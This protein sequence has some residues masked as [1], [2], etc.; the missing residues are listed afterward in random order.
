MSLSIRERIRAWFQPVRRLKAFR[1]SPSRLSIVGRATSHIIHL[2]SSA[3]ALLPLFIV[4]AALVVVVPIVT[5]PVMWLHGVGDAGATLGTLLTAQAAIAALTLAVTLFMMQGISARRD[6]DDRMNREYV[7]RSWMRDIL[8]GSLLAVGVTGV[9]LLSE[10]FISA[11][12]TMDDVKP[13]LHNLVLAAGFAFLANLAFAGTLFERAIRLSRPEQWQALR[14]DVNKRDV[15]NAVQAFLGRFQRAVAAQE[16]NEPDTTILFPDPGEGSVE[17]AVRALLDDARRAMSERR[18]EELRRSLDSIRELVKYAMDEIKATDIQWSAPGSQPEWPPL[19]ELSHNL[20]SFREDVIREG[21]RE[22]ILELLSFDYMLTTEGIRERCGELFTVGL[23]GHRWNYQIAN[24]IGGGDFREMLRDRFSQNAEG[25]ILGTEPVEI[26]LY[27]REM[28]KHQERLLSDALHSD[29]P[30]DYGQLHRGFQAWLQVIRLHWGV[31]NWPS[32][33]ASELYQQLEQKYR[34]ALMGL[35]GRALLLA[36]TNRLTDVNP[37]LDVGRLL[38]AHLGPLV[39]D[40]APALLYDDSSGFSLWQEWEIEGTLPYQTINI[41]AERYP[42]MFFTLRLMELSYDTMPTFN[43]HGRAQRALDWFINNS[44][45]VGAYVRAELDPTLEQRREFATETLRSAVRGDEVAEDYEVIGREL[46]E[47]RVSALKSDVYDAAFSGNSVERLFKRAGVFL[48]VSG[49]AADAPKERVLAELVPKAFLTDMPEGALTDYAP[50]KGDRWGMALS[51][52]VLRK[53][54][55][56]LEGAPEMLATLETPTALLRAI[57]RAIEDL[58]ASGHVVVV[59]AGNWFDLQVG[60]STE[61]PEGYEAAW[62]LSE[63]DRVGE[64]GRYR[65]H[66]ILS[67]RDHSG[68]CVYVVDPAEWG[69]FV[70]TKTD[71]DQDLRVEIKPISIDQARELLTANPDHFASQP[72][73]KSKLRKLQTCV[74]IVIGARAGFRV[75]DTSRARRV[76][77]IHQL[78]V[79]NEATKA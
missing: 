56:A 75:T 78:D 6:V 5:P 30:S 36:Q 63:S 42:L 16:A 8:W 67:A 20:Y 73:A 43:L 52:D 1:D 12:G 39:D 28:V 59:L 70:R 51:Q 31:D 13:E 50:L 66:P 38:Y 32:S 2:R 11:T 57:D 25:L 15:Q 18:H 65:G 21:D 27:A 35:G 72:D 22:Y 58:N 62:R 77:P 45:S 37:Y 74:K 41:S 71:G 54:C 60:L 23:N 33:E 14:H 19:R 76:A 4:T 44:E 47:T 79:N 34:V 3:A 17:E 26:F 46:S 64:I 48:Y 9:L 49:D 68:Q 7:R 10:R 55:E 69:H 53:F 29:L 61:N 24:R 40:L